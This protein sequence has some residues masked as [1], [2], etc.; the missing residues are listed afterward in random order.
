MDLSQGLKYLGGLL[1]LVLIFGSGWLVRNISADSEIASLLKSHEI[2]LQEIEVVR[3]RNTTLVKELEDA[4]SDREV[5]LDEIA[6]LKSR[7]PEVRYITQVET[8]VVGEPTLIATELPESHVFRTQIG[9]PV[10]EFSVEGDES[11]PK[12]LFDTAD[13]RIKAD[14]VIAERDSALS[15]RMESDLE[16][17]TE[18]EVPVDELNVA[19]LQNRKFFEPNILIGAHVSGGPGGIG[20]GPQVGVSLLHPRDNLDL[21]QVRIG[22]TGGRANIGLDPVL[23][24]L[25]EPLPILTNMWIGAGASVD[26][27][28]RFA[29]TL[30]VGAKL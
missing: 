8:V 13:L 7:P 27:T 5:L 26:T 15:I 17:G 22:T 2:E 16:P 11:Q 6:S 4:G 23:Y 19:N 20:A 25:G 18:Y 21:V 3:T 12:Y 28:G 10:A 29:G 9:L 14:L 24:N 30:S 1:V